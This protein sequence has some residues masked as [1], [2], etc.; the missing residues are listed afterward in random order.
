MSLERQL[1]P[2]LASAPGSEGKRASAGR[3]PLGV[4]G[5]LNTACGYP[6]EKGWLSLEAG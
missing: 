5:L 4:K 2:R 1:N 6:G 3:G